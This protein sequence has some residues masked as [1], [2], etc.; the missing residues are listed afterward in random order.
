LA[1]IARKPG[2]ELSE[3]DIMTWMSSRVAKHKQLTGG[4]LFI[5]EVP[6]SPSGKIQRKVLREWAKR[7]VERGVG[8]RKER[9]KL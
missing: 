4:V 1:Y 6:K 2:A 7:D 8:G 3:N 9:A 5:D